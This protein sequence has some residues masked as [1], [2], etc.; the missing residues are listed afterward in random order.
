M[1]SDP[2]LPEEISTLVLSKVG[3]RF[4]LWKFLFDGEL[5]IAEVIVYPSDISYYAL[6]TFLENNIEE[7]IE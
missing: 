7:I 4:S 2:A 1:I 6:S 5:Q 3:A